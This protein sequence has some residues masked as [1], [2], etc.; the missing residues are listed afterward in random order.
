MGPI[1][2][3]QSRSVARTLSIMVNDGRRILFWSLDKMRFAGWTNHPVFQ[4]MVADPDGGKQVW[5]HIVHT[6]PPT[7][8]LIDLSGKM[9]RHQVAIHHFYQWRHCLIAYLFRI[10][11]AGRKSATW[12]WVDGRGQFSGQQDTFFFMMDRRDRNGGQQS[13][14]IR[15]E[16]IFEQFLCRTFLY[17]TA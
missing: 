13:F 8:Y 11:T 17:Q 14:R 12:L 10:W 5:E 7:S 1:A 2:S 3:D 15:V 4:N 16:R 6:A 9:A